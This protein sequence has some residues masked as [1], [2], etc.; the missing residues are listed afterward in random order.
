MSKTFKR[1]KV[2]PNKSNQPLIPPTKYDPS[3]ATLKN[4]P[5]S[6]INGVTEEG[7]LF[8]LT[9]KSVTSTSL[10]ENLDLIRKT[11]FDSKKVEI[12]RIRDHEFEGQKILKELLEEVSQLK[13]N[14]ST[15][16]VVI[17]DDNILKIHDKL[18]HALESRQSVAEI[19][20]ELISIYESK[21]PNKTLE[22]SDKAY[23]TITNFSVGDL[24]FESYD[25]VKN[26]ELIPNPN[27]KGTDQTSGEKD[28]EKAQGTET[29]VEDKNDVSQPQQEPHSQ[30]DIPAVE[31]ETST[32]AQEPVQEETAPAT[33]PA[34][35]VEVQE[36]IQE[37]VQEPKQEP[38]QELV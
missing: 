5:S 18:Q 31:G 22:F 37:Q 26:P 12:S 16:N 6:I 25:D 24:K 13:K 11:V 36:P 35:S 3:P 4:F 32:Q 19:G 17:D 2:V 9:F 14:D 10:I 21:Y 8:S 33:A 38:T 27:D 23:N 20:K 28:D 1:Q 30:G 7:G 15:E 34:P 29:Q